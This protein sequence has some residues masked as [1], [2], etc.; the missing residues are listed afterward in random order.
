MN[1]PPFIKFSNW[2]AQADNRWEPVPSRAELIT[3][4]LY[5]NILPM[6]RRGGYHLC[7]TNQEIRNKFATWLYT[8]DAEYYYNNSHTLIIPQAL[9]RDAQK[10]RNN[11]YLTFDDDVWYNI[12]KNETWQGILQSEF[13][14]DFFW[15]ALS[16][17]MYRYIDIVHSPKVNAYDAEEAARDE[18][19]YQ[20]M[21]E[22]G[23]IV[24]KKKGNDDII[25]K[26][27]GKYWD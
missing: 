16:Q 22:Q 15:A 5:K 2:L 13:G 12:S 24:E 7:Y 10:D 1:L 23:L 27:G 18:E 11:W 26:P 21:V 8:I 4:L 17:F 6:I 19:E 25:D 14:K 9:H 20:L 3:T